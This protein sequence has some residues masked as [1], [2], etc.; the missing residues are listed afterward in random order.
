MIGMYVVAVHYLVIDGLDG[1]LALG[2]VGAD[3]ALLRPRPAGVLVQAEPVAAAGDHAVALP[4]RGEPRY[5]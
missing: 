2:V 1:C 3:P 5:V 4:R